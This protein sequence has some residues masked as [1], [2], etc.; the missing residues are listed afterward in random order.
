MAYQPSLSQYRTG[1]SYPYRTA[2]S[3]P[4]AR[5]RHTLWQ[6]RTAHST[7]VA[8]YRATPWQYCQTLQ[9]YRTSARTVIRDTLSEYRTSH[10]RRDHTPSQYRTSHGEHRLRGYRTS[11]RT[12]VA[13]SSS[14]PRRVQYTLG[15]YR[16]SHSTHRASTGHRTVTRIARPA[17]P[18]SSHTTIRTAYTSSLSA[19]SLRHYRTSPSTRVARHASARVGR[20][21]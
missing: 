9:Q 18:T 16:T 12:R 7:P 2:H 15:H 4:V 17:D 1:R 20:Y 8:R 6:Y 19:S 13:H 21:G 10:R 3:T 14:V 5:Y 11:P